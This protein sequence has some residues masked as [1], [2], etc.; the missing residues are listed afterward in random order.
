MPTYQYSDIKSAVNTRIHNKIGMLA[1]IRGTINLAA[2]EVFAVVDLRSAKRQAG[3]APNLFSD[4]YDYNCPSD[5]KG[6]KAVDLQPQAYERPRF[7]EWDLTSDAEFDQYKQ[8][9]GQMLAFSDRSFIR[10]LRVAIGQG[11]LNDKTLVIDPL[12]SI[13][14]NGGTWSVVGGAQNLSVDSFNYIKGNGSLK[15]DIGSGSSP[16]AGIQNANLNVSDITTYYQ[17]GSVFVFAYITDPTNISSYT[18]LLGS[19]SSNYYSITVSQTNEST[20]FQIGWNILRFDFNGAT[21]VGTPVNT[22]IKYCAIYMNKTLSKINS[23]SYRF[24]YVQI[25][26]GFIYNFIYYSKYPWQT[27]GGIWKPNSTLDTDLINAD[28]DEYNMIVE[29]C[30]EHC[31]NGVREFGVA[32]AAAAK[33]TQ[34]SQTYKNNFP[35][36]AIT[37]TNSL[38][39]FASIDGDDYS[40][41]VQSQ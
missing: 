28:D 13:I 34:L 15:F 8:T 12:D 17:N 3:L 26:L 10:K 1:D 41:G 29:K 31:A 7:L 40:Y 23:S 37:Q 24:D 16:I 30:I 27:S 33:F 38:H 2:K 6:I 4:F 35:S 5:V 39:E 36:D 21:Q 14:G 19:D 20:V 11:S 25:K 22:S 9:R 32:E 18:I